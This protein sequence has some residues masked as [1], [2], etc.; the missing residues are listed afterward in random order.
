MSRPYRHTTPVPKKSATGRVA[1]VYAQMATDFLLDDGPLMS[2]SPAPDV[3]AGTW[4]LLREAEIVGTAARADKEAVASAVS[5]ANRC[6]FCTEAHALLA[7]GAGDHDLAEAARAGRTPE[8]RRQAA[9]LAWAAA[10][11][12]PGSPDLARPP[13]PADQTPEFVGTALATHFI[14]R[15]V[16][17]LLDEQALLPSALRRSQYVRRATALAIGRVARV[18]PEPGAGLTV[19]AGPVPAGPAPAWAGEG[20]VG[21]AYLALRAAA[22]AGGELLG[23]A[24]RA[25]VLDAVAAWD[26][27]HPPL[28][29]DPVGREVGADLPPV[30]RPAARLALLA[31]LAPYRITEADVAAWRA[32]A[33]GGGQGEGRGDGE[34]TRVLA[35]GAITATTRVESWIV[36]GARAESPA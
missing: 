35:F 23:E 3:L 1:A 25:A 27:G 11:R 18:S 33:G 36:A 32:A 19:L 15:M 6:P 34:L 17:S 13:F 16:T 21:P 29:G 2:L 9:L 31:A 20:P 24:G 7:H 4:A 8:D 12:S 28:G 30:E 10:T 14:N 22:S 5:L 26:G